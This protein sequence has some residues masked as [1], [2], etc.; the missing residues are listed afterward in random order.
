MKIK[1]L[2]LPL[3]ATP[4]KADIRYYLNG[5]NIT[6]DNIIGSD[7]YRL[8]RVHTYN[9]DIP[10]GHE[11]IIVPVETIKALLKKVG[12]K[13]DSMEVTI[14][15]NNGRY[16]LTCMN[17][18]EVFLPIDHKYPDFKKHL[19]SVKANDHNVNLNK[20]QHQF[21]W[22]YVSEA[23]KAIC[24]YTGNTTPK[25]LYSTDQLGYFMPSD[26]I[27]YIIMPVRI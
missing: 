4:K 1:D 14:F 3:S 6:K 15:L 25:N 16:E 23:N 9:N 27:I 20:I 24:K 21:N 18:V 11:N 13:H 22:G 12:A 7:G 19:D 5:V 2:R 26:D 8:C 10:E 17:Q